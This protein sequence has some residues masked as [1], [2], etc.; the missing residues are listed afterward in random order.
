[1]AGNSRP[2][3]SHLTHLVSRGAEAAQVADAAAL[4]WQQ[5]H[6]ALSPIVGHN[7]VHALVMRSLYLVRAEHPGLFAVRDD[8]TPQGE[9]GS[10]RSALARQTPTHAAGA[11]GAL[12]QSF[13]DL[14]GSLIGASLT[15]RL[16]GFLWDAPCGDPATTDTITP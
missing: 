15:E 3:E 4:T 7:G 8:I 16:L 10:L 11:H 1:M 5:I 2:I 6:R 14:L 13:C 9:Y 12:L